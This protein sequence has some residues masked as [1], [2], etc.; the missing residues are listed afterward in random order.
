ML[1]AA[2]TAVACSCSCFS[3]L[4]TLRGRTAGLVSSS[5]ADAEDQPFSNRVSA[6]DLCGSWRSK[7]RGNPPRPHDCG[8][9]CAEESRQ[10]EFDPALALLAADVAAGG[11]GLIVSNGLPTHLIPETKASFRPGI[12]RLHPCT[13][14]K[15]P[16]STPD[17]L[18]KAGFP[19]LAV[20]DTAATGA[21]SAHE[22]LELC[23]QLAAHMAAARGEAT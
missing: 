10:L 9:A 15:S 3:F 2:Q 1:T 11:F 4:S 19:T 18:A 7:N 21:R 8:T 17:V 16:D 6:E 20:S 12:L 5:T 22:A 23:A 14:G 13:R